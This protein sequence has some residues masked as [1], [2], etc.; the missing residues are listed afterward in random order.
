MVEET[1]VDESIYQSVTD[2]LEKFRTENG[3]TK[4]DMSRFFSNHRAYY[5]GLLGGRLKS[6]ILL[7]GLRRINAAYGTSWDTWL[8]DGM[9]ESST[10]GVFFKDPPCQM[11]KASPDLAPLT[12]AISKAAGQ[13]TAVEKKAV[14]TAMQD[15]SILQI[16]QVLVDVAPK[17]REA[18]LSAICQVYKR[19]NEPE[20]A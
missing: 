13:L 6:Q 10:I 9:P 16:V 19:A 17:S 1:K 5:S 14:L 11:M 20:L 7:D 15:D 18:T 8:P 3:L 2:R 4:A 12:T